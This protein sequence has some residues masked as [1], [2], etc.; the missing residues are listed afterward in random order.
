MDNS[1]QPPK[2]GGAQPLPD[3]KFFKIG[4]AADLVGVKPYILRY[5]ESE[6]KSVR[7]RKTSAGHRKYSHD[8]IHLLRLIK[9]L[10]Y[11][12]MFTI[13]GARQALVNMQQHG[14]LNGVAAEV[15]EPGFFEDPLEGTR[16]VALEQEKEALTARLDA[17][18]RERARAL[19]TAQLATDALREVELAREKA[20][21]GAEALR[22]RLE[23]QQKEQE[24]LLDEVQSELDNALMENERLNVEMAHQLER[25]EALT[26][27]LA[28]AQ[29]SPAVASASTPPSESAAD[30]GSDDDQAA[31]AKTGGRVVQMEELRQARE[32]LEKSRKAQRDL[33]VK[34]RYESSRRQ[35][36]LKDV[37]AQV[38]SLRALA[39]PAGH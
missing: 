5:W 34:L 9:N 23:G 6:F 31:Q 27:D 7:P 35:R 32:A 10:L 38:V 12:Q 30:V 37:R 24:R 39:Q 29:E 26:A 16:L 4:E 2:Q 19:E 33:E 1:Q 17:L 8:D 14:N 15:V 13:A 36:I 11:E 25:I 21:A 20:E 28:A 3:K 18:S 22:A